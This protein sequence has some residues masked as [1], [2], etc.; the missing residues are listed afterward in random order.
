MTEYQRVTKR[1][2]KM[3]AD[4]I[5]GRAGWVCERCGKSKFQATM[6]AAHIIRRGNKSTRWDLKNGFC[7]CVG[8]HYWFDNSGNRGDVLEWLEEKIG[9]T[10]IKKLT[11]QG[12]E[13]K[14][15]LVNDLRAVKEEL[16]VE[17]KKTQNYEENF[18]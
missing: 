6:N 11:L 18:N 2:D 3:W 12:R 14:Q 16:E 4:I 8:C 17:Q 5:K 9:R 13:S 15:W 1:C 7:L 10:L